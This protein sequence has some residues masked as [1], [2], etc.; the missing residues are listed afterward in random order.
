MDASGWG[1][2]AMGLGW[3]LILIVV[4]VGLAF[5]FR[6]PLGSWRDSD[7]GARRETAREI[8]DKRYARGEITKEQYD[9]MKKA[10]EG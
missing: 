1:H 10:L 4:V 6:A 3:L 7:L 9:E 8:L 2:G 5:L